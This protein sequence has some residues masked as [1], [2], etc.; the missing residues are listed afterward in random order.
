MRAEKSEPIRLDDLL[1]FRGDVKQGW[2]AR[3]AIIFV[4]SLERQFCLFPLW[5]ARHDLWAVEFGVAPVRLRVS[6]WSGHHVIGAFTA[7]A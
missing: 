2:D 3:T 1:A 6:Q 5:L 7:T 4:G